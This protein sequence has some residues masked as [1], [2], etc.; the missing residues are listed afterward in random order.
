[1]KDNQG[2]WEQ[3]PFAPCV[4]PTTFQPGVIDPLAGDR[5][6][7]VP[8]AGERTRTEA[9]TAVGTGARVAAAVRRGPPEVSEVTAAR[10]D[11]REKPGR[12]GHPL[13]E[14]PET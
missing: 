11:S 13:R 5:A 14:D 12:Y 1:M 7:L 4:A 8:G 6:A 10:E 3:A 2:P 9:V